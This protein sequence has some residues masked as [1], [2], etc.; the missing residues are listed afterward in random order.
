MTAL[1][2][3]SRVVFAFTIQSQVTSVVLVVGLYVMDQLICG[4]SKFEKQNN[5]HDISDPT[6]GRCGGSTRI[7]SSG[8]G[9][10]RKDGHDKN[11]CQIEQHYEVGAG[12]C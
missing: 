3:E 1:I 2:E 10:R 8:N 11:R 9:R 5:L 6:G 4:H 12:G 7:W